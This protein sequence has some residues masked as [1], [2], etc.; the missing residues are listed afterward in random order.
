MDWGPFLPDSLLLEIFLHLPHDAVLRAGLTCKQWQ[1]VSKDEFLWRELFYRYYRIPRSVPRHPSAVSWYRE[2]KRL[3]DCIPCVEVQTL[4]EHSDQV[5]HLAFS[6][7]GH[8]F[9]SCSKDCT[10]KLWDT[11]REDGNISLVHSSSMRQFNWGYTQFSQFNPDDTLLLVSGVYLGPHHSSS[12]E[13]AVISLENY[14]L[15]SRVRNKPYDVFGCWLNETHLI[16]G[17]LHWI[18]NMTSCSVLWLNKAFQ[19]IESENVNVVKRLFKIQNINASTIR[20]VMVAHCR[21]H[22]N[23]DLLLDYEAQSQ[24]RRLKAEQDNQH[25]PL[26]F[27]LETPDSEDEEEVENEDEC[28]KDGRS[29]SFSS[30]RIPQ[31]TIS[32]LDHV[33]HSRKHVGAREL[34]IETQVAQMMGRAYT[35]APDSSLIDPS[36]PREGED[37]TYLLFTTGSLTYSPHQIGIKLIKPDQMTTS[38]PVLGEERSSEEF[39]DSLDHVI[40]IHGHIIGMGLSPDH[41]YLY[42]NSRA[43]PKGC[44]ISD[45]MSPPPIAEEIDMH[46]IDLKSLREERRSLRAHRAFT[47]NDECFF[48]FLDVSRDFVASGAEDK[49]GYIWDR[50][51]NICLARLAH[52]DVVN[53]VAFSPADQELLLTASDD[54]TIK[55]WRSPR[56]VRLA[57]ASPRQLRPC[58]L[59]SSW[60]LRHK[61]N[62]TFASSVNGK[63]VSEGWKK[64]SDGK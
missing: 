8:R 10:V 6:H 37:K 16:S 30:A 62:S 61:N 60:L 42:V 53:S 59:L 45:P 15:L 4:R 40:D 28:R 2:F 9:S 46:V 19:D 35:K 38:G 12:G 23:P 25:H 64:P 39:F 51:Y 36:E 21:R 43:W 18:G 58:S 20:T 63:T 7:R 13:I 57:Q 54:S 32:G 27:D 50:H 17:N 3:Y 47:P 11:E 5:L 31:L 24:A 44:V 48:I 41:R 1:A 49:H 29:H 55:V 14:T 34:Q 52:D 56:M 22:D 33:I 26:L